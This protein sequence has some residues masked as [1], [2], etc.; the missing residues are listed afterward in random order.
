VAGKARVGKKC[1]S[2]ALGAWCMVN[3]VTLSSSLSNA[4]KGQGFCVTL[5]NLVLIL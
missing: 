5:P 2:A 1:D 3:R 4:G